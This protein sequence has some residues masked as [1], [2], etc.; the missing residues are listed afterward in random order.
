[1]PAIET[2]DFFKKER[3]FVVSFFAVFRKENPIGL[4]DTQTALIQKKA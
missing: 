3:I 1:M 4:Y 2:T